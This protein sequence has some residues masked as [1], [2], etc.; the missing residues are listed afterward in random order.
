MAGETQGGDAGDAPDRPTVCAAIRGNGELIF[1]HFGAL[2]RI[3]E[4][5]GPLDGAAGGSSASITMFLTESMQMNPALRACPAGPCTRLEAGARLGLMYKSLQ[6]YAAGL[7]DTDEGIAFKQLAPIVQKAMDQGIGA[8]FDAQQFLQAKDALL[9]L[10]QSDEL[11]DLVN[12]EVRSLL[13]ESLDP[14]Y[15]VKDIWAG[16]TGFGSFSAD[17]PRILVRPGIL[18]FAGLARKLGRIGSFY[19]AYGPDV[20]DA[21]RTWLDACALPTR[22]LG[23]TAAAATPTDQGTCGERFTTLMSDYRT[24]LLA[25][26]GGFPSRVDDLVGG[27]LPV[28]VSTSVLTGG[29]VQAFALARAQYLAATPEELAVSFGDVKF[30][31]WGSPEAL[32]T[33]VQNPMG[34]TDAKTAKW[35]SLGQVPWARALSLSPAEP[36]LARAMPI[37]PDAI[38]P[39]RISAGGWS[40][41]HPVLVLRNLGCDKVIYITRRGG[42]SNFAQA[43][44]RLLGMS[45]AAQ[46]A[47]YDLG[48]DSAYRRS[49]EAADAVW[50]T[51]WNEQS[52]LDLP[53]IT[54]DAYDAP[55]ETTDPAFTAGE[56][57]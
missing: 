2:A 17:T 45:D 38:D 48:A 46:Q 47:L 51:D 26:E 42:E 34:Y 28:L 30:G 1:A 57:P 54:A 19:A 35:L 15:H 5:Y 37:D 39:D 11:R 44:A 25:N 41:L 32:G 52:G 50:C 40:D 10:F 20:T 12:G 6:G 9:Q 29:A 55:M 13:T 49:L 56:R 27:T 36:G 22:G 8:L 24:A 7:T 31:Y 16:L 14:I 21:W 43:V 33:V 53:G 23:W 4:H 18:D 3:V